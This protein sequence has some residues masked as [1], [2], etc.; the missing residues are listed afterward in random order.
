MCW[1]DT[2][3]IDQKN[4]QCH[5]TISPLTEDIPMDTKLII[6]NLFLHFPWNIEGFLP[7]M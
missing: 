1:R 5:L 7:I 6:R 4:A 2:V 3:K